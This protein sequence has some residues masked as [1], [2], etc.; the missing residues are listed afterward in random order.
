MLM[1]TTDIVQQLIAV[2]EE[3]RLGQGTEKTSI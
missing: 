1:C 3:E 2:Y